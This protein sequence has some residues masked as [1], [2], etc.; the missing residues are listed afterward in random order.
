MPLKT[1]LR[2]RLEHLSTEE[3]MALQD[4]TCKRL[5]PLPEWDPTRIKGE[6]ILDSILDVLTTRLDDEV[7]VA[8]LKR[9]Y[10]L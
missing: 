6:R 8:E 5:A 3:L 9:L 4:D 1:Y 10:A 2:P 7:V